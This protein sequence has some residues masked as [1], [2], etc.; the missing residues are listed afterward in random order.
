V[1]RLGIPLLGLLG[2]LVVYA[3]CAVVFWYGLMPGV[4]SIWILIAFGLAGAAV[5]L[6]SAVM[7]VFGLVLTFVEWF[8]RRGS[9][10]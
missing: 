8:E 4:Y 5:A 6:V 7:L 3:V 10:N 1:N 2:G 9:A